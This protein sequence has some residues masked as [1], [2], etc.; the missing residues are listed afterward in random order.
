M[1]PASVG[2]HCPAC[3]REFRQANRGVQ[4][5]ISRTQRSEPR[6]TMVLIA[7]CVAA[8]AFDMFQGSS[9]TH[10]GPWALNYGVSAPHL[11]F[12]NEWYRAV[13]SAFIHSGMLH[14]GFNCYLL[15]LLG[16]ALE[17]SYGSLA[18]SVLYVAGI[19]GGA[20]GAISMQPNALAV[21]ASG[22]VFALMG[23]LALVQWRAGINVF[24]TGIGGL[25][26]LNVLFS[27]RSGVSFGG[28]LG[29]LLVGL[30]CGLILSWG[31]T[32]GTQQSRNAVVVLAAVA[33]V[34]MF[35]IYPV[36]RMAVGLS[37]LP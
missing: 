6:A 23:A 35:L 16:K 34:L 24:Q 29:G 9:I 27:F 21:G 37:A 1:H 2:A 19:F 33:L 31:G 12:E 14:L 11:A 32:R 36:A 15:W 22:A 18:F 28:H 20:L 3:V 4:K 7:L 25:I 8:F 5:Q 10:A 17:P 13:S 30:L 26:L